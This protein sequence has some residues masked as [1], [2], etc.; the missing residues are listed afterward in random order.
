[1]NRSRGKDDWS[2]T[3][4]DALLAGGLVDRASWFALI[5][6]QDELELIALGRG[7]YKHPTAQS[8]ELARQRLKDGAAPRPHDIHYLPRRIGSCSSRGTSSWSR[9][10]YRDLRDLQSSRDI[11]AMTVYLPSRI[12]GA[13]DLWAVRRRPHS[14]E[15]VVRSCQTLRARRPIMP[16]C[17]R[18]VRTTSRTGSSSAALRVIECARITGERTS[19]RDCPLFETNP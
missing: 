10:A 11:A 4:I 1:M 8:R 17:G 9:C 3:R 13:G 19:Q 12:A 7:A 16:A 14:R 5:I 6:N 15:V 18:P 2:L